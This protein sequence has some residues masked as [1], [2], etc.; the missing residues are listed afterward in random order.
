MKKR[1]KKILISILLMFITFILI[2]L[3]KLSYTN[4]KL[5]NY[6][7]YANTQISEKDYKGAKNTLEKFLSDFKND[8]KFLSFFESRNTIIKDFASKY[9]NIN[10]K[11][12][13]HELYVNKKNIKNWIRLGNNA[14]NKQQFNIALNYYAKVLKIEPKNEDAI[15]GVF[16][17]I[18]EYY[19]GSIAD[20]ISDNDFD[21][22][23]KLLNTYKSYLAYIDDIFNYLKDQG[24]DTPTFDSIKSFYNSKKEINTL[25]ND[26]DTAKNK[27]NE[28]KKFTKEKAVELL[29][30]YLKETWK[31]K[32][33]LF[34]EYDG[35]VTKDDIDEK[36]DP[37]Y[38]YIINKTNYHCK[39]Y[40][41]VYMDKDKTAAMT[42][43]IGWY[44][45]TSD[46][47]YSQSI[48]FSLTKLAEIKNDSIKIIK[49]EK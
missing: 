40:Y 12:E 22:A 16:T 42:H 37:K 36:S 18:I 9:D 17:P 20:A 46:S 24:V 7:E 48:D 41:D 25:K 10:N 35:N 43:T 14:I 28:G 11:I 47:I 23:Y 39:L 30:K 19:D 26:I 6:L 15:E 2:L 4:N 33:G 3:I 38:K 13:N 34:V 49:K 45:V 8:V 27:Y 21:E 32:D 5:N 31:L 44:V 29:K 1:K